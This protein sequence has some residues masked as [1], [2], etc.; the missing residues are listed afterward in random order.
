[1]KTQQEYLLHSTEFSIYRL[2]QKAALVLNT[3]TAES[4]H[5][6]FPTD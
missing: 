6:D 1:M 3:V 4:H 5:L 2:P